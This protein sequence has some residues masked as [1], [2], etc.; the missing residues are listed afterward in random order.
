M[1]SISLGDSLFTKTQQRVLGLLYGKPDTRFY[2]N[3]ILRL[4]GMGRGT[5]TRIL[6]NFTSSGVLVSFKEGNQRYYQ[7]NSQNPIY[8]E[9]VGIVRKTF[10]ISD[11]IKIA[12]EPILESVTLAFV[13]G[14]IAK[15]E[16]SASS[17]IDLMVLTDNLSYSDLMTVLVDA[18]ER[19]ARPINP[20]IYTPLQFRERVDK[21]NSFLTRVIAQPKLWLKG[22]D[23]DI[24]TVR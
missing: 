17:D 19:L 4:A 3:E 8:N 21:D 14:S 16:E 2:T 12:L 1:P 24:E 22:N 11:V 20:T 5:I 6:D 10:G 23:D 7:A 13:Y 15:G 9:L 18:E